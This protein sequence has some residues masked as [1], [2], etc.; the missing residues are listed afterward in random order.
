MYNIQYVSYDV[1]V[2]F[3]LNEKIGISVHK[4]KLIYLLINY[5]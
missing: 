3:D 1:S 4:H 2:P 5:Y